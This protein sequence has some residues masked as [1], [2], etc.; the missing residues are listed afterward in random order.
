MP[1]AKCQCLHKNLHKN[2]AQPIGLSKGL[3]SKHSAVYKPSSLFFPSRHWKR[4]KNW[5]YY[6]L[7]TLTKIFASPSLMKIKLSDH[8]QNYSSDDVHSAASTAICVNDGTKEKDYKPVVADSAYSYNA[9][10][11]KGGQAWS[12]DSSSEQHHSNC[13]IC[14]SMGLPLMAIRVELIFTLKLPTM[15]RNLWQDLIEI[16]NMTTHH[17][18]NIIP[19]IIF[20]YFMKWGY[21]ESYFKSV[22]IQVFTKGSVRKNLSLAKLKW[23]LGIWVLMSLHQQSRMKELFHQDH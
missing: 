1:N 6:A 20:N 5:N 17:R 11:D 21:F 22:T 16:W 18:W 14:Q 12:Q 15:H 19:T 13:Y 2:F 9:E 10:P 3:L 8:P 4:S 7:N 23:F